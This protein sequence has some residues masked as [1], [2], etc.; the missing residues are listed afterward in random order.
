LLVFLRAII[1]QPEHTEHILVLW[2]RLLRIALLV[3]VFPLATLCVLYDTASNIQRQP[4]P[5]F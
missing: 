2:K 4:P 5:A 3:V 1:G